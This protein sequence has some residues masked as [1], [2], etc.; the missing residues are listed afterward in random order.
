MPKKESPRVYDPTDLFQ[1]DVKTVFDGISKREIVRGQLIEEVDLL[2]T[3]VRVS[4]AL[5]RIPKGFIVVDSTAAVTVYRDSTGTERT[6]FLTLISSAA[7][8]VSLWVF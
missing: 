8:T 1:R 5:G 3:A 2:T 7:A 6:K 4:H